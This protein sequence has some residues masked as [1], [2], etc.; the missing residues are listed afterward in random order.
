MIPASAKAGFR[1]RKQPRNLRSAS[2]A[3]VAVLREFLKSAKA[4]CRGGKQPRNSRSASSADVA[5]L[6]EFLRSGAPASAGP[7]EKQLLSSGFKCPLC[8]FAPLR[9]SLFHRSAR[10]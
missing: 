5:V 3:D 2:S 8:V 9:E 6:R 10:A 1:G 7:I 4:A